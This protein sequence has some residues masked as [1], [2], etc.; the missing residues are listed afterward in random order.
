MVKGKFV[1]CILNIFGVCVK[2]HRKVCYGRDSGYRNRGRA[3]VLA[4]VDVFIVGLRSDRV[5]CVV[6]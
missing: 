4:V 2:E 5:L 3:D 1:S 6:R